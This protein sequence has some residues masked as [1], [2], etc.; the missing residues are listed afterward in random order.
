MMKEN[1]SI[2]ADALGQ[3]RVRGQALNIKI[4]SIRVT[5]GTSQ[6]KPFY[7]AEYWIRAVRV[8]ML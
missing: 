1:M 5:N 2:L 6:K 3:L 8:L 7:N 4:K